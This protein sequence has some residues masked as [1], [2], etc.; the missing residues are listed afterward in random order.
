MVPPPADNALGGEVTQEELAGMQLPDLTE[1]ERE[2][3]L[4]EGDPPTSSM[5]AKQTRRGTESEVGQG[6]FI[7]SETASVVPA[8]LVKRILKGDYLDFAELLKDNMEAE[9]RRATQEGESASAPYG[10][11]ANRREVPDMLSWLGCF[12]LY[13]AVVCSKHPKKARELWAYQAMI[14]SEHRRCGG[15]GWLLY[16]SA[17]RQQISSLDTVDFSKINQSLYA[18]T[19]LAHSSRG[20]CC[21]SCLMPDHKQE[22]CAL[23][24]AWSMPVVRFRESSSRNDSQEPPRKRMKRPCFKWNEGVCANPR[25]RFDPVCQLC[26]SVGH[27]K[28]ECKARGGREGLKTRE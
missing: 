18:T 4:P 23:N 3:D 15:R 5:R 8:K 14:I 25:C 17:F 10:H 13:A 22:D 24:P 28:L 6:P 11:R 2:N 27:K 16:D 7:L 21:P 12:S 1:G 9:R 26:Y 19:F 20:Q